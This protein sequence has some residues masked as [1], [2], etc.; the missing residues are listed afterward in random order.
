MKAMSLA[1]RAITAREARYKV[2]FKDKNKR[3][4]HSAGPMETFFLWGLRH[5]YQRATERDGWAIALAALVPVMHVASR[6]RCL[7][8]RL[9]LFKMLERD[10]S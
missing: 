5:I 1:A 2:S 3:L 9:N 4:G 8:Y 7:F 6:D 10:W